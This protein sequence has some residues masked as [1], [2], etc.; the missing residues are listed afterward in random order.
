AFTVSELVWTPDSKALLL[1]CNRHDDY[2]LS[3][4][5]TEIYEFTV[6]DG[7]V[8]ALTMRKGPDGSPAISPD[9]KWIAYTGFED[10]YQGYQVTQL[11]VMSR[12]GSGVKVISGNFDRDVASPRWALDGSGI[13]FTSDSKG[14]T[15]L[16]FTSLDGKVKKLLDN[17]GSSASA[18]GGGG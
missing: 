16:Y 5:D 14:N 8:K 7:S 15:G 9:G 13:Y 12:N 2:E 10:R 3:P 11:S 17:V 6:A 18:Y 4:R 1:S